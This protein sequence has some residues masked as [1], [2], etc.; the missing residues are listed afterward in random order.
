MSNYYGE[1]L[2]VDR[3]LYKHFGVGVG[4]D[5]VIHFNGRD[6]S[7]ARII[8]SGM[9]EFSGGKTVHLSIG[10]SDFTKSE[11]VGRAYSK[12]GGDFGGYDLVNNNCEHFARWCVFDKKSSSQVFFSNDEQDIVE[13]A[14]DNT[15]D[16]TYK[17]IG[18]PIDDF[19][20]GIKKLFS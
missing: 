7:T 16:F 8:L 14:I 10:T 13:K 12:L 11:V 20:D 1:V 9:E 6:F 4:E 15:F 18:K 3:G 2:Y 5:L 17:I 19:F